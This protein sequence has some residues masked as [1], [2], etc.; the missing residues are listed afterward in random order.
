MSAKP[1]PQRNPRR[2]RPVPV[3]KDGKGINFGNKI[4]S[5]CWA[6]VAFDGIPCIRHFY[7]IDRNRSTV[8]D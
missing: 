2:N 7:E 4:G 3:S 6:S 8:C 5:G 1:L